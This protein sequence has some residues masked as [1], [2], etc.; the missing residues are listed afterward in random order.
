MKATTAER[1]G[2]E[3]RTA[4]AET[5]AAASQG[6]IVYLTYRGRRSAAVVSADHGEAITRALPNLAL[7]TRT[8]REARATLSATLSL[9]VA[10]QTVVHLSNRGRRVAAF[11]PLGPAEALETG[12]LPTDGLPGIYAEVRGARVVVPAATYRDDPQRPVR[13]HLPGRYLD[14]T[15][16]EADALADGLHSAAHFTRLP[17]HL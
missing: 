6:T 10:H 14:L 8:V 15:P 5:I 12:T 4:F 3:L 11:V 2:V 13:L 9:V 7:A 17:Q 16:T 1:T